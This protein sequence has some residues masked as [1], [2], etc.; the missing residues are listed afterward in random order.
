MRWDV[1]LLVLQVLLK[2]RSGFN[3][4]VLSRYM[5]A[6]RALYPLIITLVLGRCKRPYNN[7]INMDT[8]R[9]SALYQW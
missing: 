5:R 3:S 8:G 4:T 2:P 1:L 9:L 6:Q 7:V